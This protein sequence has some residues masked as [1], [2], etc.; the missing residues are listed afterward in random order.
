MLINIIDIIKLVS[1]ERLFA[2]ENINN[3]NVAKISNG[4]LTNSPAIPGEILIIFTI[5]VSRGDIDVIGALKIGALKIV[6]IKTIPINEIKICL[7]FFI[8]LFINFSVFLYY[9]IFSGGE[10]LFI[11]FRGHFI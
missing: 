1:K 7:V 4:K 11:L 8:W 5:L 2:K 3:D 10:R 9:D 6:A